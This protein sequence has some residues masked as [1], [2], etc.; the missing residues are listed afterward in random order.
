VHNSDSSFHPFFC[1][2]VLN[3]P[4]SADKYCRKAESLESGYEM[5]Y[6]TLWMS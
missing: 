3:D 1:Q 4:D 6:A 2:A 5:E